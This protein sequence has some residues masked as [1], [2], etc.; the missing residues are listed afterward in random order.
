ME[1]THLGKA[2]SLPASPDEA[3]LDYVPNPRAGVALPRA[4][5]RARNSRRS[6]R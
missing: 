5:C 6:A 3:K 4:I 1:T 2:S